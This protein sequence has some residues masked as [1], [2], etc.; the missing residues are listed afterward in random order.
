MSLHTLP[1]CELP[2]SLQEG[3]VELQALGDFAASND[4]AEVLSIAERGTPLRFPLTTRAIEARIDGAAE[5]FIGYGER[6]AGERFDVVLWPELKDC[7]ISQPNATQGYPGKHGGQ[8][9]GYARKHGLVFAAGGNDPLLSDAIVG[10]LSF[11][12]TTGAVTSFDPPQ[13]SVLREARAF[14]TVSELGDKL[15]VAGGEK[16]MYG[17]G[18]LDLQVSATAEL[19]DPEIERFL[20]EPIPLQYARTRHAA[21]TLDDGNTLLVGGRS[22][23]TDDHPAIVLAELISAKTLDAKLGATLAERIEPRAIRL[24]DGRVFVGGGYTQEGAATEPAG[25]WLLP[26]GRHEMIEDERG[27]LHP[28]TTRGLPPRLDR[29]FVAMPGGGVLA[30]GG[31]QKQDAIHAADTPTCSDTRYDA[32]WL[33][34]DGEAHELVGALDGILAP[35]PIL[36]PGSDGSPWLIASLASDPSIPRLFRFNPWAQGFAQADVPLGL[37]LPRPGFPEP[38]AID[39]DAFI[40]ID[41]DDQRGEL[42]GV[43]FGTRNRYTQDLALVLLS[44]ASDPSRPLHLVPDRPPSAEGSV[45][46]DGRLWFTAATKGTG[47]TVSVADTDYADVTVRVHLAEANDALDIPESVPPIIILGEVAFGSDDCPWPVEGTPDGSG[48]WL[49][50]RGSRVD[51]HYRGEHKA[52][53]APEGRRTLALRA[54]NG[55]S[56]ITEIEV[57]RGAPEGP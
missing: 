45:R 34:P 33:D 13:D 42:L 12:V 1:G 52:C 35:R 54:G 55:D 40:W 9:L 37:R 4:T 6:L 31:C 20:G 39:P 36:L 26:D 43:R 14:A 24:S 38:I 27:Q 46:Y 17:V 11:D 19:F 16:P 15:V 48:P 2:A 41:E 49:L 44:D 3:S 18:E 10:A 57:L 32:W 56:V 28:L 53:T 51:L 21:V 30:V 23:V 22:R 47:I 5:R 29:A 7:A 25:E 50:R 8:A